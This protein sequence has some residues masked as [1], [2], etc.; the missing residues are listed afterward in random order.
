M[1]A[2]F[3]N[4][5]LIHARLV[6]RPNRFVVHIDIEGKTEGASLPNPGKLGELFVENCT[7]LVYHMEKKDAKYRYRVAGVI[8]PQGNTI[9]LDTH[10]NNKVAHYLLENKLIPSLKEYDIVR[11]EVQYGRSRFDFLLTNGSEELYCEVKSC[12]LFHKTTAMFPDAVT[13]RGRRHVAELG[14]LAREGVKTIVL[15]IIQSN[16]LTTFLPDFHTDPAFSETLY[17]NRKDIQIVP[18]SIGWDANLHLLPNVRELRIPWEVYEKQGKDSGYYLI[19]LSVEESTSIKIGSKGLIPFERGYYLYVG[20]AKKGLSKRIER[21]KRLRKNKHWH[22][23]YLREKASVI[24]A[25][26]IRIQGE[27]ECKLAQKFR[28]IA[29]SEIPTFGS[30]DC[31]C[32]GHLLYFKNKPT[33]R[34]DFQTLILRYR[35]EEIFNNS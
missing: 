27:Y 4:K 22:L 28:E 23:D 6:K 20:S 15:F 34:L 5:E 24:Q 13:E 8:S 29:D 18:V 30:S 11:S 9:M 35:M 1:A 25:W 2:Q 10:V 3:F 14:E 19:L 16:E 26:P 7:L 12:T 33:T 31:A 17:Q 21:H 32:P